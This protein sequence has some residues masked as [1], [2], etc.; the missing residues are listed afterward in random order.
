MNTLYQTDL[1]TPLH[2]FYQENDNQS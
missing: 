1:S 2:N